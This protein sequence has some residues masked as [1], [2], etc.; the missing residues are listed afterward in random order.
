[1]IPAVPTPAR[2]C[3]D[4]PAT[5]DAAAHARRHV[6]RVLTAWGHEKLTEPA[7]LVISEL[8]T[9]A[10]KAT[11]D[12]FAPF[13]VT[14]DGAE[15]AGDRMSTARVRV[16]VYLSGHGVALEV[17]DAN[18]TPPRPTNTDLWDE[19]GRGLH[20]VGALAASWGYRWPKAGGKIVYAVLDGV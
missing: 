11:L 18:H 7:Q 15:A 9:N 20:I 6:A 8:V 13:P 19:G 4:L 12:A 3:L 10:V 5:P 1:M 16:G 17:W 2:N 14:R